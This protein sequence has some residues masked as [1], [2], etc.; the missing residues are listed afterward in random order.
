MLVGHIASHSTAQQISKRE[1]QQPET[2][3][4]A[5]ALPTYP[6][7][8]Y[9]SKRVTQWTVSLAVHGGNITRQAAAWEQTLTM[10]APTQC[11]ACHYLAHITGTTLTPNPRTLPR[12]SHTSARTRSNPHYSY[13]YLRGARGH[14]RSSSHYSP[15]GH[16]RHT[17]DSCQTQL[18]A[19]IPFVMLARKAHQHGGGPKLHPK[20]SGAHTTASSTSKHRTTGAANHADYTHLCSG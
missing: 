9:A 17:N 16:T 10:H 15:L 3:R 2:C 14:C 11:I 4:A 5:W 13:L 18:P 1:I 7:L 19:E 8:H 6:H 12:H 20:N